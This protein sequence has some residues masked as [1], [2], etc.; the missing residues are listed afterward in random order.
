MQMKA[1]KVLCASE[2]SRT[3]G[4]K[5]W[6][7]LAGSEKGLQKTAMEEAQ[8][9]TLVSL[10]E[11]LAAPV[12]CLVFIYVIF[13]IWKL[14]QSFPIHHKICQL[15]KGSFRWLLGLPE[16]SPT[17]SITKAK[18]HLPRPPK[19]AVNQQRRGGSK[20]QW[21]SRFPGG[22]S[23]SRA[24]KHSIRRLLC[25]DPE[26]KICDKAAEEAAGFLH[27]KGAYPGTSRTRRPWSPAPYMGSRSLPGG[28][29]ESSQES[30]PQS[31]S[32]PGPPAAWTLQE[33]ERPISIPAP[34]SLLRSPAAEAEGGEEKA[35]PLP[36]PSP[37][38]SLD[39]HE[40]LFSES[41]NLGEVSPS[42]SSTDEF[43]L[44]KGSASSCSQC[45]W[46]ESSSETSQADTC[47]SSEPDLSERENC[48]LP[49]MIHCL[50]SFGREPLPKMVLPGQKPLLARRSSLPFAC[51]QAVDRME[52]SIQRHHLASFRELGPRYVEGIHGMTFKPHA[53][54]VPQKGS[55]AI[56]F[57]SSV[58]FLPEVDRET[59][60]R[61]VLKKNV[62]H[63]WGLPIHVQRSLQSFWGSHLLHRPPPWATSLWRSSCRRPFF[64]PQKSV[65]TWSYTYR[66]EN[67]TT[68][69]DCL[70]G[71]W[72]R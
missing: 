5:Q 20:Q 56:S 2:I 30:L 19:T 32:E 38:S 17:L 64:L 39:S 33:T 40:D 45:E 10:G 70:D 35:L 41:D 21:A 48:L 52:M 23:L 29:E 65:A 49:E 26:C 43:S 18:K 42:S 53:Q 57:D 6:R 28:W 1:C 47:I 37:P 60:E 24:G 11:A 25:D 61:H 15:M 7:L 72:N 16:T 66:K 14:W 71:W 51:R 4:C 31:A 27:N 3:V 55:M 69:G 13:L 58:S 9:N 36:S 22:T 34:P 8:D 62:G 63:A 68:S 67:C 44:M 50:D 12:G 46:Y 59:L 54:P